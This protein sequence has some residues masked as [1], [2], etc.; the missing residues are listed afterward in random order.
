ML[1]QAL[2]KYFGYPSF[3]ESQE[4]IIQS[5]LMK[6]D[7]LGIL[8]TGNGKSLCYQL[9]G[10]LQEGLVVI[11]APLISLMEDQVIATQNKGMDNPEIRRFCRCRHK[12]NRPQ[13]IPNGRLHHTRIA[14]SFCRQNEWCASRR[15]VQAHVQPLDHEYS[16]T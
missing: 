2:K 15:V 9:T 13:L 3:R 16:P 12:A 14:P 11:V 4:E 10:Y 1:E 8:P 6:K 5:L 7:T